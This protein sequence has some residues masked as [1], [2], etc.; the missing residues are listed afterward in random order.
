VAIDNERKRRSLIAISLYS[1]G[2]SVV[3]DGTIVQGDRQ[4]IG[5]G[6]Y[7]IAAQ[8]TAARVFKIVDLWDVQWPDIHPV[9]VEPFD[10]LKS[11]WGWCHAYA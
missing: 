7:G 5:Y 10:V 9:R 3:P 11:V 2:P 8:S 4:T 6:Y 1:M